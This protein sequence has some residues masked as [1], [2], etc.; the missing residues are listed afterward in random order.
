MKYSA[1]NK[2]LFSALPFSRLSK[3]FSVLDFSLKEKSYP[4]KSSSLQFKPYNRFL[5][6]CRN[7]LLRNFSGLFD[8]I[9][10]AFKI[11]FFFV[12]GSVIFL[13]LVL[14]TP[15]TFFTNYLPRSL[16]NPLVK[17]QGSVLIS[18][19]SLKFRYKYQN[20]AYTNNK[21]VVTAKLQFHKSLDHEEI[22]K[23][24]RFALF[25][26]D[27]H[28]IDPNLIRSVIYIESGY[29]TR[30]KSGKGAEGLMQLMPTTAE[31]MGVS[32]PA[33]PLQNIMGGSRYLKQQIE[34]FQ[35]DVKLALAAYNAGPENVKKY[36][37]IPPFPET[38]SYV[39]KV[40]GTY[41]KLKG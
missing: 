21:S 12:F 8:D 39:K 41:D 33:N 24:D 35:G 2:Y 15:R 32:D 4:I 25:A 1:L 9:I 27:E 13:T 23:I 7:Y 5:L 6:K 38:R 40:L 11:L 34:Y 31:M 36:K 10:I 29:R 28:N 3:G 26:A 18:W 17:A 14:Y 16:A 20:Y 30:A 37:G 22:N 19:N